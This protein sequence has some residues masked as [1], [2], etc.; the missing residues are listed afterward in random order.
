[1]FISKIPNWDRDSDPAAAAAFNKINFLLAVLFRFQKSL[2]SKKTIH[3]VSIEFV[4][5]HMARPERISFQQNERIRFKNQWDPKEKIM[6]V[7]RRKPRPR[8][9]PPSSAI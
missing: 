1:M 5:D 8:E 2:D 7:F 6:R 3:L 9:P 4:V